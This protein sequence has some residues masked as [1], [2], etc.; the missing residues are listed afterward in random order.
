MIFI[1]STQHAH[2]THALKSQPCTNTTI[3]NRTSLVY[4]G[5]KIKL[6]LLFNHIN[7]LS[8]FIVLSFYIPIINL[9][10]IKRKMLQLLYAVI[11]AE[12]L[13]I[14]SFLFKTPLRKLVIMVL[15]TAKRGRGPVVVKTVTATM[16]VMLVSALYSIYEIR[17]RYVESVTI[18][19]PTEQVLLSNHL[20]QASLLG[21]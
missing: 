8:N 6:H 15:N 1:S 11:F 4:F 2:S 13:M 21:N 3:I 16:V 18:I 12:M 10:R 9:V 20:L 7:I 5:L 14:M 19:D 17:C